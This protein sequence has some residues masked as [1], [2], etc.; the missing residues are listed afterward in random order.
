MLKNIDDSLITC[1]RWL[2]RQVELYSPITRNLILW[3]LLV[4]ITCLDIFAIVTSVILLTGNWSL[5]GGIGLIL[6]VPLTLSLLDCTIEVSNITDKNVSDVLPPQRVARYISRITLLTVGIWG[7]FNV[8]LKRVP[9]WG[10]SKNENLTLIFSL[11]VVL[12]LVMILLE[13]LFCTTSLS[14]QEKE[15]RTN[16]TTL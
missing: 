5:L 8:S 9:L 15:A 16:N 4:V 2:V 11:V 1:V 6:F 10:F 14:A 3:F 7:T 12:V 13:Y